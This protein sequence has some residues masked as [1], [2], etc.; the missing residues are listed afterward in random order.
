M[1][2]T[3]LDLTLLSS[4]SLAVAAGLFAIGNDGSGVA[5]VASSRPRGLPS[6]SL[7]APRSTRR[8]SL[9]A[10]LA[11]APQTAPVTCARRVQPSYVSCLVLLLPSLS[12]LSDPPRRL[13]TATRA[14][15]VPQVVGCDSR[16]IA[17]AIATLLARFRT[18]SLPQVCPL[19]LLILVVPADAACSL[20]ALLGVLRASASLACHRR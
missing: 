14:A 11:S 2:S 12:P 18:H 20:S 7:L 15:Q 4:L 1:R 19:A 8:G 13:L 17:A 9:A 6:C 5:C 3:L 10:V 16:G